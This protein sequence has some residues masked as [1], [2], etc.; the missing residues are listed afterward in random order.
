MG[1]MS[2]KQ[3]P[4]QRADNTRR[5][6]IGLQRGKKIPHPEYVCYTDLKMLKC[7]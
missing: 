6:L 7:V 1:N 2:K 5:P 4:D 3:Q